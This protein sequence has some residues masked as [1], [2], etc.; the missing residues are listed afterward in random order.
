MYFQPQ[1][2]P[3][4]DREMLRELETILENLP[5]YD[6]LVERVF[7]DLKSASATEEE[8]GETDATQGRPGMTAEQVLRA[9]IVKC[10]KKDC[11]YRELSALTYDSIATRKFMK[12][13]PFGAGFSFKTLQSN[14]SKISEESI[15][16]F[17]VRL[18]P[19]ASR[20]ALK[21]VKRLE[22]TQHR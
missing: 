13:N 15:D 5:E 3:V 22:Q 21:M 12:I 18:R 6:E 8:E 14:V 7:N 9:L 2:I 1:S 16:F 11:P 20:K 17:L 4:A 19:L 10:H